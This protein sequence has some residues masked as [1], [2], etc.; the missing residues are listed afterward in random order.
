MDKLSE[1]MNWKRREVASRSRPVSERELT[2]LGE[3]MKVRGSFLKA[4]SNDQLSVIAEIKR[5]SPSAGIIAEEISAPEQAR[6]YCNA[7]ADALSILTDEKYFGGKLQDLWEVN[8][9]LFQHQRNTPTLRKDFMVHPIQVLEALE[10]GARAILLI[11]RALN[12]EDLKNLRNCADTAGLDCL[13][14]EKELER[15]LKL[16]PKILGVNNRDLR[17]F[18]TD[19]STTENLFP[20]IPDGIIK[21]SES[22]ILQREDAWRVRDAGADAI[23]CGEALMK[24]EDPESFIADAKE[25][26]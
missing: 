17:K 8:D 18:T 2:Q 1:I 26:D 10:A 9:F 7:G 6:S 14:E 3:R 22:G 16:D 5:K 11:V 23:L 4:L 15:A 20:L 19:L 13:H 21:V 25:E 12:D 24:S